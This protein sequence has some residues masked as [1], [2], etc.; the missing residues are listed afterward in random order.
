MIC[1]L[2]VVDSRSAAEGEYSLL[3]A[4]VTTQDDDHDAAMNDLVWP[5][6]FNSRGRA[7]SR[8][9]MSHR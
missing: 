2:I 6:Q 4:K 1:H 8:G 7:F 5:G 9:F 3:M